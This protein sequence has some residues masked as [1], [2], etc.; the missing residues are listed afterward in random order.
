M[1]VHVACFAASH[2]LSQP[3]S[4]ARP[5]NHP[6]ARTTMSLQNVG[7][8]APFHIAFFITQ[9]LL[10]EP[11]LTLFLLPSSLC[12]LVFWE[13]YFFLTF[14]SDARLRERK[15]SHLSITSRYARG[16]V[17]SKPNA[18]IHPKNIQSS[19]RLRFASRYVKIP[20]IP[21]KLN[22]IC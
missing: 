14:Q 9:Y 8:R 5:T 17:T 11:I 2:C 22:T 19:E 16:L 3:P 20:S 18:P 13:L 6:R 7:P 12:S 21:E 4:H 10:T 1:Q 15:A